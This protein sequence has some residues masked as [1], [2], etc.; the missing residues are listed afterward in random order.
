[1]FHNLKGERFETVP[2]VE[3]TGLAE[4]MPSRGMAYGDLFNDGRI[5]AVVNNM[6]A[7][8][9]LLRNVTEEHNH[10]V[11]FK[12]VGGPKSPRD[13]VGATIYVTANGMRQRE[14]V[15]S[16]GSFISSSDPRPHFGIGAATT[17]EKIEIHWPSGAKEEIASPG[18][19][20]M[21]TIV[22]GKGLVPNSSPGR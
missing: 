14:D 9:A 20:R 13:A 18:L 19:D 8:P 11:A 12:L 10:W 1:L 22:E 5:D 3:G 21:I 16:G 15:I 2:A 17:I 7:T 4:V 6:D